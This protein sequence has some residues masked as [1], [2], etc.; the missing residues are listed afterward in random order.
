MR[1]A[2]SSLQQVLGDT[3]DGDEQAQG[4]GGDVGPVG[5]VDQQ[6]RSIGRSPAS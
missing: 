1:T 4:R 2:A 6:A 3:L 5:H